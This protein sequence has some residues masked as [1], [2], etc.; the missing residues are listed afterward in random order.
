MYF[1]FYHLGFKFQY[2]IFEPHVVHLYNNGNNNI[3]ENHP[4]TLKLK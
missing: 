3:L 1:F 4:V 2:A